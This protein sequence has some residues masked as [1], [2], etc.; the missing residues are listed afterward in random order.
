MKAC[1]IGTL[2]ALATALAGPALAQTKTI[3]GEQQTV[4]VTVEAIE[5]A[6][7]EVTVKKPDGTYSVFYVPPSIK[8]FDTLTIGDKVTAK[9]YENLVLQV[10]K[11]DE[12]SVDRSATKTTPSR[13]GAAATAAHQRTITA[14]ITAID[15]KVPSITFSGPNGWTYS[16]KVEDKEALSKVKVGDR[17]DI[18]WTDAM[19]LSIDD[20]K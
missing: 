4:T 12:K 5:K 11:P 2:A 19:I 8:R 14:T 16:S 10:K 9:Y 18:T 3:T 15:M 17:V 13:E 7:R 6:S 20:G 1:T